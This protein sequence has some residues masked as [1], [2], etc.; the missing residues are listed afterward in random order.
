VA[1]VN[2]QLQFGAFF[3]YGGC[4]EAAEKPAGYMGLQCH[5]ILWPVADCDL[6]TYWPVAPPIVS[7]KVLGFHP[8]LASCRYHKGVLPAARYT[9]SL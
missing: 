7:G 6:P 3:G 4:A 1:K 5:G 9:A 8:G 2:L